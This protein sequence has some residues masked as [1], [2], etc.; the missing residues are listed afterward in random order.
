M[1]GATSSPLVLFDNEVSPSNLTSPRSLTK[2]ATTT[3]NPAKQNPTGLILGAWASLPYMNNYTDKLIQRFWL[4]Y[5]PKCTPQRTNWVLFNSAQ[6]K[7]FFNFY[8]FY[9]K[10]KKKR[11]TY[12]SLTKVVFGFGWFAFCVCVFSFVF[13]AVNVDFLCE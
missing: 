9:K 7:S 1:I 6:K 10:K 5:I 8:L 13:L 2:N 3:N 12:I 11:V 4:R